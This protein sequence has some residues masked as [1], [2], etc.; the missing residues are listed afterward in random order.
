MNTKRFMNGMRYLG[1]EMDA[2]V[3]ILF[4]RYDGVI[5]GLTVRGP[6]EANRRCRRCTTV[7]PTTGPESPRGLLG[8]HPR[9]RCRGVPSFGHRI[10]PDHRE[11]Y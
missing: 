1:I 10:A 6:T 9:R 4:S 7:F 2:F 5:S 3:A 8:L 11:G